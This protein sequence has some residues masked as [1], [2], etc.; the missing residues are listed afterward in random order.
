MTLT[1]LNPVFKVMSLCRRVDRLGGARHFGG[2]EEERGGG[3]LWRPPA[4]SL[5]QSDTMFKTSLQHLKI[6]PVGD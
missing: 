4:Y 6:S 5:L 2:Q 1:D 3:A